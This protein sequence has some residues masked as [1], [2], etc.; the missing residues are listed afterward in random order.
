MFFKYLVNLSEL[1]EQFY[2]NLKNAFFSTFFSP[3][4]FQPHVALSN[5]FKKLLQNFQLKPT[6]GR[7]VSSITEFSLTQRSSLVELMLLHLLNFQN[8]NFTF[9]KS[10][11]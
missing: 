8:N 9:G 11:V 1:F 3:S 7:S 5:T 6:L 2:Q 10:Q 4:L